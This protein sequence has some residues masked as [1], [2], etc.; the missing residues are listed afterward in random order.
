[1]RYGRR[2]AVTG[3]GITSP[4]GHSLPELMTNLTEGRSSCR[5]MHEW[6][7]TNLKTRVASIVSDF[8]EKKIP[9]NL[10]R[11]MSRVSQLAYDASLKAIA[12]SGLP[13]ELIR[14]ERTGIAYGST[15]GGT[16][17]IEKSYS[18]LAEK[19]H[20]EGMFSSTFLQIMSHTCASN[21]V[22]ALQIPGRVIASCVACAAST[23]AIGLGYEAVRYGKLDRVLCGGA[24]EMHISIATVFDSLFATT[25]HFNDRPEATPRPFSKDRD[26]I[27]VGEGS[28]TFILE[29]WDL[30]VSRG[31]K[32]YAEVVGFHTNA[33]GNHMTNPSALGME[34][35]ILGAMADAGVTPEQISYIN[36]HATATEVGDVAEARAVQSIFGDR[37]PMSSLKGHFGHLMGACG[38]VESAACMGMLQQ[39]LL[40]PTLHLEE[41]DPACSHVYYVKDVI[42]NYR[43][44]YIVKN[45]FAFGGINASLIFKRI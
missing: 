13:E 14:H 41:V 26:G 32:I 30:A 38:V 16:S 8:D 3:I 12:D 7:S 19:K 1:M 22:V 4:L 5:Y 10:R 23:Q 11:S 39:D 24:E 45:S 20:M 33:D 43:S 25:S 34:R 9:R 28:G 29:D 42:R 27:V 37:V 18:S 44:Q 31:A 40:V 21:L 35:V 15:M 17:A 36:A 2:V 6:D